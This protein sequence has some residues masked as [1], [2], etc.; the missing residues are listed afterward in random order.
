MN[1]HWHNLHAKDDYYNVQHVR[2]LMFHMAGFVPHGRFCST[3]LVFILMWVL[4]CDVCLE[5]VIL[6]CYCCILSYILPCV[7]FCGTV[8]I[9]KRQGKKIVTAKV[10]TRHEH[11]ISLF[12]LCFIVAE[13]QHIITYYNW[14]VHNIM[15]NT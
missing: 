12:N 7:I 9:K 2:A 10:T 15:I 13:L 1:L 14:I 5:T 11:G 3:L 8:F 4:G 6:L